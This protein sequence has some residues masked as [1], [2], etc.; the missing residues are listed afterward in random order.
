MA[1]TLVS[2]LLK[3]PVRR[4]VAMTGEITLRGRVM[5]IGGVKEKLLAAHRAGIKHGAHPRENRKDLRDVPRRVLKSMRVVLV[6][7]IDDVLREALVLDARP[8][9]RLFAGRPRPMEYRDGEL[10]EDN[11]DAPRPTVEGTAG[12]A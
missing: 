2:A 9:P 11:G 5:A 8:S 1:T 3:V 4:D 6:D 10:L 12:H 7:H